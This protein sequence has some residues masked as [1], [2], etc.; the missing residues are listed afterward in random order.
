LLAD[1]FLVTFM[2]KGSLIYI[3]LVNQQKIC[4]GS[5]KEDESDTNDITKH[6]FLEE[7][8]QVMQ[9]KITNQMRP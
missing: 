8:A 3:C 4:P 9:S 5:F 2:K 1:G 6:Y 7:R